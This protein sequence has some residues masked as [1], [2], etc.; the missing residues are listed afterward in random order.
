MLLKL[1]CLS[2]LHSITFNSL[3]HDIHLSKC[4]VRYNEPESRIQI[5][6]HIF[7]DDLEDALKIRGVEDLK[8]GTEKEVE[9]ADGY[10]ASYIE[11]KLIFKNG[12]NEYKHSFLGKELSEDLMAI[13][14][15]IEISEVQDCQMVEVENRILQELYED[16]R[17]I[18]AFTS[19]SG[20]KQY[21]IFDKGDGPN[22]FR[23][24]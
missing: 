6:A 2:I 12:E 21:A 23:C 16:Q 11:S 19:A 20:N 24:D 9:T 1:L 22:T 15:Y 18:L 13:W 8:I 14:C 5:S 7:I 4:E 3:F 10:I 17:N